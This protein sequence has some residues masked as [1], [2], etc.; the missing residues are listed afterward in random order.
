MSEPCCK[1]LI[2]M[3]F[4]LTD[5]VEHWQCCHCGEIELRVANPAVMFNQ[6]KE[7][8]HGD[9]LPISSFCPPDMSSVMMN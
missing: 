8:G 7:S 1:H 3:E 4:S 5:T 6:C 2:A 9:F